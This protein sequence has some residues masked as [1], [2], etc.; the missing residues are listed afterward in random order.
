MRPAS[1]SRE[2]RQ[3]AQPSHCHAKRPSGVSRQ[4]SA[5]R[6]TNPSPPCG[7]LA[8]GGAHGFG[9]HAL[10]QAKPATDGKRGARLVVKLRNVA[11]NALGI[12]AGHAVHVEVV[13][14]AP[15]QS[16]NARR[17][18]QAH[19]HEVGSKG[20]R[21]HVRALAGGARE[22]PNSV[23]RKT[24]PAQQLG[25]NFVQRAL[26]LSR[27][28]LPVG[29]GD[30][31][32]RNLVRLQIKRLAQR[33]PP[34][35]HRLP[36]QPVHQRDGHVVHAELVQKQHRVLNVR[37]AVRRAQL[38]KVAQVDGPHA[39][40]YAAWLA[41]APPGEAG[42]AHRVRNG[43]ERHLSAMRHRKLRANDPHEL[44]QLIGACNAWAAAA[45]A[46][47][48]NALALKHV[49]KRRHLAHDGLQVLALCRAVPRQVAPM[50]VPGRLDAKRHVDEQRRI[51]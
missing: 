26:P 16:V 28:P 39:Q 24:A 2:T 35:C 6:S 42:H 34:A 17:R 44:A 12:V 19:A 10:G 47:R 13:R 27:K 7:Q 1:G 51:F 23:L 33:L 43:L 49:A 3:S 37:H 41:L 48:H 4:R 22:P 30:G 31:R 5:A 40:L 46:R 36:R 11:H 9:L 18:P 45:D 8:S 21:L 32:H 29:G 50:R 25:G 38:V 14:V 15:G 20:Q